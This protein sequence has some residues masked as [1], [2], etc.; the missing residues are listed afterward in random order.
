MKFL[1][2]QSNLSLKEVKNTE[3]FVALMIPKKQ[4]ALFIGLSMHAQCGTSKKQI[5]HVSAVYNTVLVIQ[6]G[7]N[8]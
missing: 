2:T 4:T 3:K 8:S 6:V 7:Y 1:C 5:A